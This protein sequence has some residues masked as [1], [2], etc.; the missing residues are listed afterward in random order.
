[1]TWKTRSPIKEDQRAGSIACELGVHGRDK[2][3]HDSKRSHILLH[4]S[5]VAVPHIDLGSDQFEFKGVPI[6]GLPL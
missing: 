1:M 2:S 3:P 5:A 4:R 6:L